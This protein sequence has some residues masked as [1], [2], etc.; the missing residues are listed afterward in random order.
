MLKDLLEEL[1]Y[2]LYKDGRILN[3][4][5]G[6]IQKKSPLGIP[7]I[8]FWGISIENISENSKMTFRPPRRNIRRNPGGNF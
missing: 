2:E 8:N 3:G 1:L 4:S 6:I 5:P 7:K